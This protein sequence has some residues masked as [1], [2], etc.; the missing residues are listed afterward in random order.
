[1]AI[2]EKYAPLGNWLKEHGGDFVK[3][4]FD[5]LNQIIPIPTH[6]YKNRPSWQSLKPWHPLLQLDQCGYVVDSIS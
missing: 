6:A 3:L 1:M 4:T 5:E 2:G